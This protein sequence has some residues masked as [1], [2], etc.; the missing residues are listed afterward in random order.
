MGKST[1]AQSLAS[2][3]GWCCRSTDKLARHPG[4]P[5]QEKPNEV[6]E[7]VA[8]HYL[9]LPVDELVA[10]VVWHYS[11]NVWPLVVSIVNTH[12]TDFS[13]DRLIMEGT[14]ILP[15]LTAKLSING[16]AA[17]WLTASNELL[18]RRIYESAQYD[19]ES[20][21]EKKM[22]DKFLERTCL[23]DERI[24]GTVK[25]FGLASIDV[26]ETSI[27]ADLIDVCL[28]ILEKQ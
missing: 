5:W 10:D 23:F 8:D 11:E 14:A 16:V 18:G 9:S 20:P 17:V 19:T 15:E 3:L 7:H 1:L 24:M 22:I 25:L 4:R 28:S 27:A 12:A 6:P 26:E 21:H 13:T 2:R